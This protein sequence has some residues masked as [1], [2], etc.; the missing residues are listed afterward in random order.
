[1]WKSIARRQYTRGLAALG[2]GDVES[3]LEQFAPNVRFVFVG[4]SPLGARLESR[5]AVR[6]W[7]GRLFRLLPGARFEPQ[8]VVIDGW[9]WDVRIAARVLIRS[10]VAGE[11]H[12]NEFCQFLRLR[13]GRV[14]WDYVMEDTQ[15][16]ERACARLAAAGMAEATAPA[17]EG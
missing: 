17:I 14:V 6:A 2:R 8:Q 11:P 1:M 4:D 5:E 9:P 3:V 13:G 10:M 15:R 16:F 7:F 12:T